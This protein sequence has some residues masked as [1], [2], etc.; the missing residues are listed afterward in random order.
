MAYFAELDKNNVVKKVI[1]AG[2]LFIDSGL[3]G[4]PKN[5]V[6]TLPENFA[7]IGYKYDKNLKTFVA[8]KAP[9]YFWFRF[10]HFFFGRKKPCHNCQKNK[11]Q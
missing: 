9:Q 6:E 10:K 5:W 2:Q 4:D 8:P 1:V 3:V 7:G 11:T